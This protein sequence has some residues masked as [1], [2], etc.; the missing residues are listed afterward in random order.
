VLI[1]YYTTWVN[2]T[3]TLQFRDDIYDHDENLARKMFSDARV[4]NLKRRE[5]LANR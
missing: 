2:E 5:Y 3:G 1:F 4:K